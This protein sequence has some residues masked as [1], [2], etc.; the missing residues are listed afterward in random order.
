MFVLVFHNVAHVLFGS[1]GANGASFLLK[2]LTSTVCGTVAFFLLCSNGFPEIVL[3]ICRAYLAQRL[4]CSAGLV[5]TLT[6]QRRHCETSLALWLQ[7]HVSSTVLSICLP[8]LM[9]LERR[10]SVPVRHGSTPP[11]PWLEF[12]VSMFRIVRTMRRISRFLRVVSVRAQRSVCEVFAL[13]PMAFPRQCLMGRVRL[14]PLIST[15]LSVL[16]Y[17]AVR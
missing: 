12:P 5:A 6:Y 8:R 13:L 2:R 1:N 11:R 3:I 10:G 4:Q 17:Y 15:A 14:R 16:R 7:V 9:L